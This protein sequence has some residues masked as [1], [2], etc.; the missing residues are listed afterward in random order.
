[1]QADLWIPTQREGVLLFSAAPTYANGCKS[2]R[3]SR[4]GLSPRSA[5]AQL[6]AR[7]GSTGRGE[8]AG[9][10]SPC[11][12]GGVPAA[13]ALVGVPQVISGLH[14]DRTAGAGSCLGKQNRIRQKEREAILSAHAIYN[15]ASTLRS[16]NPCGAEVS[17]TNRSSTYSG[18]ANVPPTTPM[19]LGSSSRGVSVRSAPPGRRTGPRPARGQWIPPVPSPGARTTGRSS[20]TSNTTRKAAVAYPYVKCI[21]FHTPIAM[22]PT[23]LF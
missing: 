4:R 8:A 1:M 2:C 22:N 9:P 7:V 11:P 16:L 10:R 13:A 6:V 17:R 18:F 5:Q 23:N 19:Q 20:T 12:R 15:P 3:K 14:T 21:L